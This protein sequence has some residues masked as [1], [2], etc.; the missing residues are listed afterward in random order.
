MKPTFTF[1]SAFLILLMFQSSLKSQGD[2]SIYIDHSE[3][4]V[5]FLMLNNKQAV[6]LA[7]GTGPYKLVNTI[8]LIQN[9][10]IIDSLVHRGSLDYIRI[11]SDSLITVFS[12]SSSFISINIQNNKLIRGEVQQ[13]A[14]D[15]II[16]STNFEEAV[17]TYHN[18]ITIAFDQ[19]DDENSL[20][21]GDANS[22]PFFK[23]YFDS[24][25]THL[26]KEN[27]KAT[28]NHWP[29]YPNGV[30]P[31]MNLIR[32]IE[33]DIVVILS[34]IGEYYKIDTE[35]K[36]IDRIKFPAKTKVS[37]WSIF[38]DHINKVEY[39]V[40]YNMDDTFDFYTKENLDRSINDK[41]I[42]N[43]ADVIIN[44]QLLI[45]KQVSNGYA[46]SLKYIK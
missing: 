1:T 10:Q 6:A 4:V 39:L 27:E 21:P 7:K 22:T 9:G 24:K 36:A 15:K 37:S 8:L 33:Q 43:F 30:M 42:K 20:N 17:L 35:T 46:Y 25:I 11:V 2:K 5:Q 44:N 31:P 34:N 18:G 40:A 29:S 32:I 19:G 14:Y 45:K 41:P 3:R 12:P 23:L 13:I 16:W 38:Y 28:F 26:N